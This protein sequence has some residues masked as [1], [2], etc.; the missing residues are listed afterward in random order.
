MKFEEHDE[1]YDYSTVNGEE[2]FYTHSFGSESTPIVI[3]AAP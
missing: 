2:N 1:Y 3:S